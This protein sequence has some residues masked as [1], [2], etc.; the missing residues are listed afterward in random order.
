[1]TGW[2]AM[3]SDDTGKNSVSLPPSRQR[4]NIRRRAPF[5]RPVPAEAGSGFDRPVR[6]AHGAAIV[7]MGWVSCLGGCAL[8]DARTPVHADA[9]IRPRT[10]VVAPVLNLSGTQ[11]FDTLKISDILA[12]EALAHSNVAVIPI[13][14]TL[15]ALA[16]HGKS[17][18]DSPEEA[19]E[20]A[21]RFNADG[22]LVMAITEFDAYTPVVGVVLQCYELGRSRAGRI[23][24]PIEAS[25]RASGWAADGAPQLDGPWLQVQRVFNGAQDSTQQEV[26][27]F[28]GTRA[29]QD[30]AFNWRQ[31]LKSQEL[32]VRYCCWAAIRTMLRE[33]GTATALE[34]GRMTDKT[35]VL[36]LA[37]GQH[38]FV[39]RFREGQESAV[40]ATF[41]DLA[42]CAES[43]F[44]WYDAAV[45]SFELGRRVEDS[46]ETLLL[47]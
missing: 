15:A 17:R 19:F 42:S 31:V 8:R 9:T 45:L 37:K 35:R 18:V 3:L 30:S 1:M 24:D 16:E 38:R 33:G 14:L 40:L 22:T 47:L 41:V 36:S 11:E 13:N 39:F 46:A 6:R 27:E 29:P 44:D 10:W 32:F 25:R 2:H 28:A 26:R 21:R 34:S 43:E 7:V 4:T 23:G 5:T 12:S 20:L